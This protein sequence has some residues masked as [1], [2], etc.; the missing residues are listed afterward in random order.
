MSKI[1]S[2]ENETPENNEVKATEELKNNT[3]YEVKATEELKN[4]TIYEVKATE[5]LKNNTIYEVKATE[6]HNKASVEQDNS[7]INDRIVSE[8]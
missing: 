4:N 8:D 5:E 6:E 2:R 3:I 1:C 7:D